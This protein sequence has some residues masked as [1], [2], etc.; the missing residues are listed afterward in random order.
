MPFVVQVILGMKAEAVQSGVSKPALGC[1]LGGLCPLGLRKFHAAQKHGDHN[2]R[3]L[4]RGVSLESITVVFLVT[5][6][7]SL[8]FEF[9]LLTLPCAGR[10]TIEPHFSWFIG[11]SAMGS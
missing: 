11:R 9:P 10:S 1:R 3:S 6:F 4:E 7:G 8:I 5:S 2:P